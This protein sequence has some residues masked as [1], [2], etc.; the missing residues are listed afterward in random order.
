MSWMPCKGNMFLRRLRRL[1]FVRRLLET[2]CQSSPAYKD[3]ADYFERAPRATEDFVVA[4][5]GRAARPV[6]FGRAGA[7]RL[8]AIAEIRPASL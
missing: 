8:R 5:A 1:G 6:A 4:V 3:W 2:R 7:V